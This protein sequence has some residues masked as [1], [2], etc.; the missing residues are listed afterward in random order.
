M[1]RSLRAVADGVS[2]L[3]RASPGAEVSYLVHALKGRSFAARWPAMGMQGE[4]C[5]HAEHA[6]ERRE[7]SMKHARVEEGLT[8]T[9]GI[10]S[11]L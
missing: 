3:M 1:S 2:A 10:L 6:A 4:S 5:I 11:E 8:R 9:T 7:S